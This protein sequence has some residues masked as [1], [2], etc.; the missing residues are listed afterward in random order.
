MVHLAV[1]DGSDG[2]RVP[3]SLFVL[4]IDSLAA[5]KAVR[6]IAQA[7]TNER[8]VMKTDSHR[9]LLNLLAKAVPG[10][11]QSLGCACC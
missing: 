2:A 3:P 7:A 11:R 9:W 1:I 4:D 6:V 5:L 8:H 10:S